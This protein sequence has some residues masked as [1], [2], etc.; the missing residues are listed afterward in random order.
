MESTSSEPSS[1]PLEASLHEREQQPEQA[2]I[3]KPEQ[4]Q[5]GQLKQDPILE[6]S[7]SKSVDD[8]S[9]N[10]TL[11]DSLP[12]SDLTELSP[13]L[14]QKDVA[15]GVP[16]PDAIVSRSE[17]D[18]SGQ[19]R[20]GETVPNQ[21]SDDDNEDT[22]FAT[23][24]STE[25]STSGDQTHKNEIPASENQTVMN[26][27][28]PKLKRPPLRAVHLDNV[29]EKSILKRES[30]YPLIEQPTRNPIFRSQWLQSTVNKLVVMSGPATPTAYT[31]NSPSMFRKLVNHATAAALAAPPP[32]YAGS[33]AARAQRPPNF[34]NNDHSHSLAESE[35]SSASLLSDKSLKRVRFSAG[36][37]TVEHVFHHDDAYESAEESEPQKVPVQ[38]SPPPAQPKKLVMTTEGVVVDDN[39]Y[40]AAEIMNHYLAACNTREEPPINRLVHDMEIASSRAGNPLLTTIN[41][42]GEP[43]PRKALDPIVDLLTLEFGLKY[44]YLDNCDL[45]DDTLKGLLYSL[46]VADTLS[47]LSLQDNKKIKSAGFKYISVLTRTLKMLNISGIPIDKRSV[48]FL[49]HAL[50]GQ[51]FGSRLEELRMDRCGLRGNLLEIIAP[52]IRESNLRQLSV[53]SNRIGAGG[54]VWIGVL[55]RDYEDQPNAT[56]PI[57]NEEQGFKRVFP[58]ISNPELLKRTHGVEI[59]DIS[60]N[61]LRQGADYVAQTLRRNLSLKTLVMTNNNLDPARLAVL[62]DALKLNIGLESLD[63][64]NN[65]ICGPEITG[66]MALTQKLA[67]NKT[68][69]K[70]I[71]S[72]AGL[73]SEGAIALAEFLPETRTLT[74]L[75]LTGNDLV[76]IAGVMALS[77]SIRMNKS[78]TC[79]DM[80]VPP[81]DAEF[82]RLSRD[83]LRACIRNMEEQTGSY[84][85]MPSPDD[86]P[87]HTIFRQPSQIHVPESAAT[88]A[89]DRRWTLLEGVASELRRTKETVNAME[90]A[91]NHEKS[92]RRAWMEHHDIYNDAPVASNDQAAEAN[93]NGQSGQSQEATSNASPMDQRMRDAAKGVLHRGPPQFE[94]LYNQSKLHQ[95]TI[96]SLMTRVDNGKALQELETMYNLLNAFMHAYRTMFALPEL[97][98]NVTVG[99]RTNSLPLDESADQSS[100]ASEAPADLS[101]NSQEILNTSSDQD[102]IIPEVLT[103]E[104]ESDLESSFLLEDEDDMDDELYTNDALIDVRRT[105]LAERVPTPPPSTGEDGAA[106]TGTRRGRGLKPPPVNTS[107]ASQTD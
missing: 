57:N 76:D 13:L 35:G 45:E 92:L 79:L 40:T 71:L 32:S 47:V 67:Y 27:T 61:D 10:G 59:L 73:Q 107:D 19:A 81:N 60:D 36:Q 20:E 94:Q 7:T 29:P 72:G 12:P 95:A 5:D 46:L 28:K 106:V 30:A 104:Q 102:Q 96:V 22:S 4:G 66:V 65:R 97:P 101:R 3:Q 41:L 86:M 44:L 90:K 50:L 23:A 25:P 33:A 75:D 26:V 42:S 52:A 82:A 24:Q 15:S 2:Q 83:I 9:A 100:T 48:E 56:I 39:I 74:H 69:K 88:F 63:L 1:N 6:K 89:E 80:N 53:R 16:Q 85:G 78:L 55:M 34:A 43:L 11:N 99:K 49:A 64:S 18:H 37:L 58:G 91:L 8:L 54:A 68:L 51:G 93:E 38:I 98:P 103:E 62:A 31:G 70:L 77:V 21:P 87:A 105:P 84:V 17:D 14:Q